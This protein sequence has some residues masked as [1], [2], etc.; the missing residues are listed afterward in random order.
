MTIDFKLLIITMLLALS[1]TGGRA[2]QISAFNGILM[3]MSG[4]PVKRAHVWVRSER[5]YALTDGK[6][7]FGLT[8]VNISDTLYVS[9]KKQHFSIPIGGRKSMRIKLAD[10]GPEVEEDQQLVDWGFGF[11]S[12]REHTGVS[13]YIGG[14]ELRRS[15][16]HDVLSAL[17]GRVAGLN[18]TGSGGFGGGQ[19]DVSM[20]GTR[21]ILGNSTPL[22]L[23]DGVVVPSFEGLNLND[24]DYV[25]VMKDA[26]IYG[27]DGGNG[28]I[29]VHTKT[30]AP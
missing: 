29:I 10:I 21:T 30:A 2:Q 25:E 8:N 20:R 27:S 22:F 19:Q 9:I 15:G 5:D 14:D 1:A 11:V 6:G 7:R 24:V 18:V 4:K 13:N 12:R 3:D 26:S 23:I 16:Q 28:A 17:Q